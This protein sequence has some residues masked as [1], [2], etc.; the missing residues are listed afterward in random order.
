MIGDD[1]LSALIGE[2][3]GDEQLSATAWTTAGTARGMLSIVAGPGGGLLVD[4]AEERDGARM[5]GHGVLSGE[6]W[7][8]FDSYGFT[9]VTP[10]TAAWKDGELILERR[11]DRGRTVTVLRI[12]GGRLEQRIDSAVPADA[13]LVP[14]LRGTYARGAA[15]G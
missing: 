15:H 4:Y 5:T 3:T 14:L 9:P 6:G 2:W 7:W 12:A 13:P 10:G 8:W 11:S 1:Q